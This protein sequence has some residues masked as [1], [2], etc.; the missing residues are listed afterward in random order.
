MHRL[1]QISCSPLRTVACT[2]R[3]RRV[4][5]TVEKDG[6][7]ISGDSFAI[8]GL[9]QVAPP[10]AEVH[11]ETAVVPALSSDILILD[12]LSSPPLLLR[13]IFVVVL[14][15]VVL[16]AGEKAG[17]CIATLFVLYIFGGFSLGVSLNVCVMPGMAG[18]NGPPKNLLSGGRQ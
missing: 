7:L 14:M 5:R 12:F 6:L 16:A 3:S 13:S 9:G 4:R 1:Q 8:V 15:L 18:V 17:S 11:R 10:E 2:A